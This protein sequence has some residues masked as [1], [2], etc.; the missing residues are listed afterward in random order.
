MKKVVN[1]WRFNVR[2]VNT[3]EAVVSA[4]A[5]IRAMLDYFHTLTQKRTGTYKCPKC[6]VVLTW[7]E[8]HREGDWYFVDDKDVLAE[9][10]AIVHHAPTL[11]VVSQ[12]KP[13]DWADM[14]C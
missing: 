9:H 2:A 5:E 7:K 1:E 6:Q 4:I 12:E 13:D 3:Q 11:L 14:K 10:K 8:E